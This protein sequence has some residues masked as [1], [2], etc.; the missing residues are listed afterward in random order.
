MKKEII[1][2][3]IAVVV[4]AIFLY[5]ILKPNALNFVPYLIY[6]NFFEQVN[7][8]GEVVSMVSEQGVIIAFDLLLTVILSWG[9]FRISNRVP[10]YSIKSFGTPLNP[11]NKKK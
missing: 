1:S 2:G 6:T 5:F 4:A 3:L 11:L 10:N 7:E 8:N 9:V